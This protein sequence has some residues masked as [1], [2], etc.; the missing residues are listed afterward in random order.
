LRTQPPFSFAE[1]C[2]VSFS[3]AL[4]GFLK[5]VVTAAARAFEKIPVV[6]LPPPALVRVRS[7]S[8]ARRPSETPPPCDPF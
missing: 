3:R 8:R 1:N 7:A 5:A 6:V 2:L 4:R